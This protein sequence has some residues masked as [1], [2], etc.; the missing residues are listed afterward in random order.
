MTLALLRFEKNNLQ[1]L[2]NSSSEIRPLIKQ[3]E[4]FFFVKLILCFRNVKLYTTLCGRIAKLR[5]CT[6]TTTIRHLKNIAILLE[7][8]CCAIEGQQNYKHGFVCSGKSCDQYVH[9]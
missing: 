1:R 6:T 9:S 2:E 7:Q 4:Q 5:W 8:A 3:G